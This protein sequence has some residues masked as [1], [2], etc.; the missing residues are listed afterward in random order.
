MAM[1]VVRTMAMALPM[2]TAL[3]VTMAMT[4]SLTI[5]TLRYK[6]RRL[7]ERGLIKDWN[8]TAVVSAGRTKVKIGDEM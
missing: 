7:S 8:W 2:T 6:T 5:G 3:T 1:T 4:L